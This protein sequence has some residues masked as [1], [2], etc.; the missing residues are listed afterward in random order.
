MPIK[1]ARNSGSLSI[2]RLVGIGD[3]RKGVDPCNLPV[4]V[5]LFWVIDIGLGILCYS[6]NPPL[7]FTEAATMA[8]MR[9]S[10]ADQ[11]SARQVPFDAS[12]KIDMGSVFGAVPS[13]AAELAA[14]FS[15]RIPRVTADD[16]TCSRGLN[17]EPFDLHR[18]LTGMSFSLSAV[19]AAHATRLSKLGTV[20]RH[21]ARCTGAEWAGIYRVVPSD[22]AVYPVLEGSVTTLLKEAYVG[23]PSRPYF[24][25]TATFAAKSNNSTVGMSGDA[26]V[27]QDTRRLGDET[28]YYSCDGS[29]R[30]ELCA[31]L[32]A[33]DGRIIGIMDVEAFAPGFFTPERIAFVLDIC[34]QLGAAQLFCV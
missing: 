24:P 25:L 9:L 31:P 23:A 10:Q 28:P 8:S 14:L 29:V 16:E 7:F 2:E 26:V 30:S 13:D 34:T 5:I 15:Y 11:A 17:P 21:V 19:D 33:P 20:I 22:A 32:R 12:W 4:A 27:I 18:A 6:L 1:M 3:N